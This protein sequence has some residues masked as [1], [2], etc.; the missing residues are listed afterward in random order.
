MA[1]K[2]IT[3]ALPYVNNVPHLGNII[4][5]VLSADVYARFCRSQG[6]ETLYI[7]ATDE[8][9]T[10]TEKKARDE[11]MTPQEVCDKY[12]ELHQKVYQAFDIQFDFFGRTSHPEHIE[13]TQSIYRD[14]EKNGYILEQTTEQTYCAH[15]QLFLADRYVEGVCPHCG[16]DSARGDQ[17]DQCG[18]LL[19]PTE[20]KEPKCQ[21]CGNAPITKATTHL[22]LDLP[23]LA[24]SLTR[25]RES[26]NDQGHWAPNAYSVAKS[27][28]ERGLLPRPITRDL[29]WGVPVPK[30]GYEDKVFY[31]WFDAPIGYISATKRGFPETWQ[32]WWM[33]PQN[34]ELYQFM[35]KDNIPFH[36]VVFPAS[37]LGSGRDWTMLH[38]I[39]STEY[40]NY[41]NDKFSK[42]RGIGVFGTDVIDLGLP[43]DLWRFY[44]L[45]NRPERSDSNFSWDGFLEDINSNFIDN[46]GNLLNRVLV[47]YQKHFPAQPFAAELSPREQDFLK[48][49]QQEAQKARQQLEKVQLKEGLKTILALGRRGNKF[50]HDAEPWKEIKTQPERA[51]ALLVALVCLLREVGILLFPYMPTTSKRILTLLGEPTATMQNLCDWSKLSQAV[52]SK[53]EILFKKLEK[54]EIEGFKAKFM[55][56]QEPSVNPLVAFAKLDIKVGEV[57]EIKPHPKAERLFVEKIDLGGGDIRTIVSGLVKHYQA[58]DLLGKKVLVVSNL[59]SA[60]LRGVESQGMV[61]ACEKKKKLEVLFS[62]APVGTRLE[63]PGQEVAPAAEITIEEFFACPLRVEEFQVQLEGKGLTLGGSP[64]TTLSLAEGKIA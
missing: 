54:K 42:S 7:C 12:H 37:Q 58:E 45:F 53:P 21:I 63:L 28:I 35:A 19:Q 5:C 44:L 64:V 20:L 15:D 51:R 26:S 31:V 57:L 32:D 8:Y 36:T 22:Y 43:I 41:E 14:L 2:L 61:L 3:S 55:G 47:F 11:N 9:G 23:Q 59:K 30:K 48:E 39:N 16:Y 18:K 10:A 50:F 29:K 33:D 24:E 4:G 46:I 6:Y 49:V 40:L 62:Q 1:K 27:W 38:H 34:T 17:C 52:A 56:K 25:F 13:I 60:P